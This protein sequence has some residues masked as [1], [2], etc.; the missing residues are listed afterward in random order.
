[1]ELR[2]LGLSRSVVLAVVFLLH[3]T[4]SRC[5]VERTGLLFIR[6][7]GDV[8]GFPLLLEREVVFL[9]GEVFFFPSKKWYSFSLYGRATG[10]RR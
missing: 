10:S 4:V 2:S 6:A 8:V 7:K 5:G 1:M 9:A 3:R